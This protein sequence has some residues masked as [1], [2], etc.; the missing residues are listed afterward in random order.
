YGP[1]TLEDNNLL[2]VIRVN[3]IPVYGMVVSVKEVVENYLPILRTRQDEAAILSV[4][5]FVSDVLVGAGSHITG[6]RRCN[7]CPAEARID[8]ID[9]IDGNG[10]NIGYDPAICSATASEWIY[11]SYVGYYGRCPDRG[12]YRYWCRRLEHEG[13]GTD[14]SPIIAAFGTSQEYTNRFGGLTDNDLINQLYQYMF[15]RNAE[16]GGLEYYNQ[17]MEKWRDLWR[18][19]HDGNST[20]ATEYAL[21]RIALDIL[22]GARGNDLPTINGKINACPDM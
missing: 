14:L 1:R 3:S 17:L 15:D 20:G 5:A 9:I 10:V 8:V 19:T 22:S 7:N 13:G 21:S 6:T 16:P 12:G 18:D 4:G 11:K 2:H